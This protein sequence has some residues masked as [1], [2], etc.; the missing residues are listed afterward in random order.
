MMTKRRR[1]AAGAAALWH[2]LAGNS[3]D[4]VVA[5]EQLAIYYERHA[6][7]FAR[8][9]EFAHLAVKKIQQELRVSRDPGAAARLARHE[10]KL[11]CR[12]ERLRHRMQS[13]QRDAGAP[14]LREPVT[15]STS[16]L[17]AGQFRPL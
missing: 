13:G 3:G 2:E 6:K 15:S 1:D 14:L 10:K 5:C 4:A 7:E 16:R 11:M 9:L 8:A 12:V 17:P